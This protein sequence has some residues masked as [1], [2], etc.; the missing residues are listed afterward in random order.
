[1]SSTPAN[2][3]AHSIPP[4]ALFAARAAQHSATP[5]Q[6]R[7]TNIPAHNG[8]LKQAPLGGTVAAFANAQGAR[9]RPRPRPVTTAQPALVA[10]NVVAQTDTLPQDVAIPATPVAPAIST[11]SLAA[12]AITP[13]TISAPVLAT[14]VAAVP[15]VL[16][17]PA[18]P[19]AIASSEQPSLTPEQVNFI[20]T[21]LEQ[22]NA[23]I[24]R[25]RQANMANPQPAD[26]REGT[27][28]A[29]NTNDFGNLQDAM[30]LHAN[31]RLYYHMRSVVRG[32][33]GYVPDQHLVHWLR[34]DPR[35]VANVIAIA[36]ER[37]SELKRYQGGWATKQIL[38]SF[39][40]NKRGYGRI[41]AKDPD[42]AARKA[43]KINRIR[44]K[45]AGR[46]DREASAGF[47]DDEP[48]ANGDQDMPNEDAGL[49]IVLD[50]TSTPS[51]TPHIDSAS[52]SHDVPNT[53]Q[54]ANPQ[55]VDANHPTLSHSSNTPPANH[56]T[57]ANII[58]NV[59]RM[60]PI[61]PSLLPQ[62]IAS[63]QPT[64]VHT[65]EFADA[66][67]VSIAPTKKSRK[68]K[69]SQAVQA[70]RRSSR[71]AAKAVGDA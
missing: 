37:C 47:A 58:I 2:P 7:D 31:R 69:A 12:S 62:S 26:L 64:D 68:K 1:M 34:Q 38:K 41:L 51:T 50:I 30:G 36:G 11:P 61:D 33:I 43:K 45:V 5:L 42:G 35:F 54:P 32:C 9:S 63:L 46:A 29:P 21:R 27:I 20:L 53:F 18:E 25:L 70:T 49:D 10:P 65:S 3:G 44:A 40:K 66:S 15:P 19:L 57:A 52:L 8:P 67:E 39:N 59:D 71:S 28:P 6:A 14:P 55:F 4:Q 17:A 16:S 48:T 13:Q 22:Q 56:G 23:E 60:I 24:E